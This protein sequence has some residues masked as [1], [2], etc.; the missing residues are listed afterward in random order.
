ME[1]RK[2]REVSFDRMRVI[3]ILGV[4]I[5]C[6]SELLVSNE[7]AGGQPLTFTWH[8]SNLVA[9]AAQF[10][11]P[12]LLMAVG[13]ILLNREETASLREVLHRRTLFLLI[14]L[15]VWSVIYVIFRF[16]WQGVLDE[17]FVPVNAIRSILST[18]VARHLWL[19]YLLLA[20]YLVLPFLRLLVHHA[21]RDLLLYGV[22]LWLFYSSVW[23]AISALFPALSFPNYGNLN[24][25]SGYLGYP[26][27]GW[28]L[29][30]TKVTP[31]TRWML[32]GFVVGVLITALGTA[33]LTKEAGEANLVFYQA[34]MPNIVV[35]SGCAFM[36]CRVFDRQTI[37]A[38][39]L[40]PMAQFA[41]GMYSIHELFFLLL[42][43]LIRLIPGLI[44]LVLAPPLIWLLSLITV[45]FLRRVRMVRLLFLGSRK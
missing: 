7:A 12:L 16:L 37:F 9:S 35:M 2:S 26:L 32:M 30:T 13:A 22:G 1:Q 21:P 25:L 36:A 10:A 38:P 44:S 33:L 4:I 6:V 42:T 31:K 20:I 34:F 39:W 17:S 23:P 5:G 14:P 11:V 19:L 41:F 8:L 29:A 15:A 24:V 27:L 3:A 40:A 43:P 28:L 45:A 18:P